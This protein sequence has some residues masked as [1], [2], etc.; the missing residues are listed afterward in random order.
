MFDWTLA[1]PESGMLIAAG[2][3][4]TVNGLRSSSRWA[5]RDADS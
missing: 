3:E 1:A 4:K 5:G 2:F